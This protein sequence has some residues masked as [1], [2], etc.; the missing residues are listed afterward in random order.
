MFNETSKIL[1]YLGAQL[2][3]DDRNDFRIERQ[4]LCG[5]TCGIVVNATVMG[6]GAIVI[7]GAVL[8]LSCLDATVPR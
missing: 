8:P 1:P 7:A 4:A 2:W 6:E 3:S 5:Y